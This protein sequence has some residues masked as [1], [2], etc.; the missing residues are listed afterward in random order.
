MPCLTHIAAAELAELRAQGIQP[1][2]EETVW[3]NDLGK[4]VETPALRLQI[5]QGQPARV[6]GIA[7][8]PLTLQAAEWFDRHAC[9]L[10]K[11]STM[12]MYC[13]AFAMVHGRTPGAF[14]QL[15]E[16]APARQAVNRWVLHLPIRHEELLAAV[17]A[18]VGDEQGPHPIPAPPIKGIQDLDILAELT[19]GTAQPPEY[20][21]CQTTSR[22]LATLRAIYRQRALSMGGS[23]PD[24][25]EHERYKA[26]MWNFMA[27]SEV[28]R[29]GR[30]LPTPE[31]HQ[32]AAH[33][34]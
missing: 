26:A 23:D 9:R 29:K 4:L 12:L 7:F 25:E 21:L 8:H 14:E 28:I 13:L 30:P 24:Q 5:A 3:L 6:N 2:D 15:S 20:W 34:N 1:T 22:A 27:A 19:A 11:S 16:Y 32:E 31:P 33:A 18:V 17:A 10:F